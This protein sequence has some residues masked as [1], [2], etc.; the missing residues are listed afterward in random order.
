MPKGKAN[1]ALDKFEAEGPYTFEE[2][3]RLAKLCYATRKK[4]GVSLTDTLDTFSIHFTTE[5]LKKLRRYDR[6]VTA[7]EISDPAWTWSADWMQTDLL[8]GTPDGHLELI[9]E[10]ADDGFVEMM[11]RLNWARVSVPIRLEL[12]RHLRSQRTQERQRRKEKEAKLAKKR[13]KSPKRK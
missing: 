3:K 1:E 11:R 9:A 6:K 5:E 8:P 13:E 2:V 10:D 7:G 12:L 4:E